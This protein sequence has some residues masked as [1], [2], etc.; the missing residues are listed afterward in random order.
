MMDCRGADFMLARGLKEPNRSPFI[1]HLKLSDKIAEEALK[2]ARKFLNGDGG[3]ISALFRNYPY[4]SAWLISH[5]LTEQ[6]GKEGHAVWPVLEEKLGVR[7]ENADRHDLYDG[8]RDVCD[9]LGLPSRGMD[10]RVD[11][12]LLHAGVSKAQLSHLVSAFSRQEAIYGPPPIETTFA[13]NRWEDAALEFLPPGIITLGRAVLWDETAWH[14]ALY[15]RI[16]SDPDRFEPGSEFEKE[17]HAC[18]MNVSKGGVA[19]SDHVRLPPRPKICWSQE[20]LVL[21]LPTAEGRI[22]V[23]IDDDA[24]PLRLKGGTDWVLD[25]PW[26]VSIDAEVSGHRHPPEDFLGKGCSFAVFDAVDGHMDRQILMNSDRTVTVDCIDVVVLARRPFEFDGRKAMP[27]GE[28]AFA[29]DASLS[30]KGKALLMDGRCFDLGSKPRRRLIVK[31]GEIA[32]GSKYRLFGLGASIHVETGLDVDETRILRFTTGSMCWDMDVMIENGSGR[33]VIED[34]FVERPE[35]DPRPL[36]IDLMGPSISGEMPIPSGVSFNLWIWPGYEGTEDTSILASQEPRNFLPDRSSNVSGWDKGLILDGSGGY[37]FATMAFEHED[38]IVSFRL[39][40]PDVMLTRCRLDGT[41]SLLRTG[42]KVSVGQED[43]FDSISIRCPDREASLLTCGRIEERPF[44]MGMTRNLAVSDLLGNKDDN[45]VILR[46]G[47]GSE[48]V[49]FELVDAL[50]PVSFTIMKSGRGIR[51]DIN[52]GIPISAIGVEVEDEFGK[53]DFYEIALNRRPTDDPPPA[54]LKASY[55][56]GSADRINL[57]IDEERSSVGMLIGRIYIR[58]ETANSNQRWCPL[59][60]S[61]GD[62]YAVPR[63]A[64]D[65]LAEASTV[66]QVERFRTVNRWISDCYAPE[67]WIILERGMVDRWKDLGRR[68][69]EDPM[70]AGAVIEATLDDFPDEASPTWV[71]INHPLEI[72]HDLFGHLPEAYFHLANLAE[73]GLSVG[74]EL[75]SLERVRLRDGLLHEQ[76]LAAFGNFGPTMKEDQRLEH[77][78]PVKFFEW[79]KFFDTDPSC[80]WFWTGRPLLGPAHLRNV[81]QQY[82]DR[83]EIARMFVSDEPETGNNSLRRENL[84][85]LISHVYSKCKAERRP[86][87]PKRN[88]NDDRS[89]ELDRW[90]ATTLSEFARASRAGTMNSFVYGIAQALDWRN[91]DVRKNMGF[92][93]RLAPELFFYYLLVWQL[94][95]VRP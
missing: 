88:E 25:Q 80:G 63:M 21:R 77:F 81:F 95:K 29:M 9:K 52:M 14:A 84:R 12:Y 50:E 53:R 10:R 6:Y 17:F 54:W 57:E 34:C 19:P 56:S 71:P 26:P 15:A 43:R 36:R 83:I 48:V 30:A 82:L 40:W 31:D 20:G 22:L 74:A 76:A 91:S 73:K 75:L 66:N 47:N 64:Y 93:L 7:F 11:L 86:E 24:R 13:L 35:P 37:D 69:C 65:C 33:V 68:I 61:R 32:R 42:S 44:G 90:V 41:R 23:R 18:F 16:A 78:S 39:P 45:M 60:N 8:F 55:S 38:E 62:T 5:S 94:A 92:L 1:S 89:S 3:R 58:P 67:C 27:I 87:I 28:G 79:Q 85:V 2:D 72:D 49:L 4:F 70:G 59:R 46:R 51:A